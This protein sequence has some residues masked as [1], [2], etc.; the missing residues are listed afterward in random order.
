MNS[1]KTEGMDVGLNKHKAQNKSWAFSR[2][3]L[4]LAVLA[5]LLSGS[6]T[7]ASANATNNTAPPFI[8]APPIGADT[9]AAF[10]LVIESGRVTEIPDRSD[11]TPF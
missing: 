1:T 10:L 4:L 5:V 2:S 8:Q 7:K 11:A 3:S 9:S 6:F